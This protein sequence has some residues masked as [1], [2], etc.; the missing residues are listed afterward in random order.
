MQTEVGFEKKIVNQGVHFFSGIKASRESGYVSFASTDV[1][2]T[3]KS[4]NRIRYPVWFG[5]EAKA[6]S[7]LILRSSLLQDLPFG[8][9]KELKVDNNV[10]SNDSDRTDSNTHNT[11]ATLGAGLKFGELLVDGVLGT[12]ATDGN[13][14]LIGTLFAHTSLTYR[15]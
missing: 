7:W 1:N 12:T 11:V 5:V 3:F 15:F 8:N 14:P 4:S 2:V 6:A 10:P 9:S 13:I